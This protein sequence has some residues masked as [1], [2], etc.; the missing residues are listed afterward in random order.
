[1]SIFAEKY[2]RNSDILDRFFVVRTFDPAYTQIIQYPGYNLFFD[3]HGNIS[4]QDPENDFKPVITELNPLYTDKVM[5]YLDR[6]KVGAEARKQPFI[7]SPGLQWIL[8]SKGDKCYLLYN[9]IHTKEFNDYYK[10]KKTEAMDIFYDYCAKTKGIDPTCS[11]GTGNVDICIERVA[12]GYLTQIKNTPDYSTIQSQCQH[13]ENGCLSVADLTNSFLNTYYA[14]PANARPKNVTMTLCSTSISAG[15]D[16][17]ADSMNIQQSCKTAFEPPASPPAPTPV[18]TPASTPSS[19]PEPTAKPSSQPEEQP[20]PQ[21]TES[22]GMSTVAQVG[23]G[24]G[25][26][27]FIV[28]LVLVIYF[29]TRKKNTSPPASPTVQ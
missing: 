3:M 22:Q 28:A 11:C 24:V 13:V 15:R 10:I 19:T 12:P 18:T 17:K 1:M 21:P 23:I 7:F 16:I 4:V 20:A 27:V 5:T 9:F 2:L 29:A 8:Y 6:N 26:F 25:V 14:E